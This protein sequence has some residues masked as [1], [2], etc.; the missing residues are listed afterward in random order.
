MGE[1]ERCR[2]WIEAALAYSGGTHDFEDVCQAIVEGKMQLW[3]GDKACAVTEIIVYPSK[4]VLHV[5]LAGGDMD[6]I[7][8]MQE[9]A[10]AWGKA[11]G[12]SSM[13]IAGRQGWKR[14][15]ADYGY[16]QMFVTLGKE[17]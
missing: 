14:V 9:S 15:L 7:L 12:C 16:E 5:I 4:K 13:T 3:A 1:L 11:Q 8:D 2:E 6:Q 10:E 17:I